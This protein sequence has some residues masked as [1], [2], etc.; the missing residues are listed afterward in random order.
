MKKT[1]IIKADQKQCETIKTYASTWSVGGAREE[2]R[3]CESKTSVVVTEKKSKN[4]LGACVE[5][6][7]K[8]K[9]INKGEMRLY[10]I[11]EVKK[12]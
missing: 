6:L 3:R 1:K 12:K 7:A 2:Q 9:R 11:K 8:F 5:C 10:S 4:E